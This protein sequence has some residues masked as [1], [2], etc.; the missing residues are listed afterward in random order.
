[1]QAELELCPTCKQPMP[2]EALSADPRGKMNL[3]CEFCSK[4]ADF[5]IHK[6]AVCYECRE[7]A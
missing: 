4:Q 3:K 6:R 5:I 2:R 1:M 7:R